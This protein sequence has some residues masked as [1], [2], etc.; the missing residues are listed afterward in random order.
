MDMF[1]K[2]NKVNPPLQMLRGAFYLEKNAVAAMLKSGSAAEEV[3]TERIEDA[4]FVSLKSL[5]S[6]VKKDG[7]SAFESALLSRIA[8]LDA[9]GGNSVELGRFW[10]A[11]QVAFWAF[12]ALLN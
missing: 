9:L 2:S 8:E 6:A 5:E 11:F 12:F 10:A 3:V 7:G 1:S 4:D